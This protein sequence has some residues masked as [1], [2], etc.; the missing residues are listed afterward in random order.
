MDQSWDPPREAPPPQN[1]QRRDFPPQTPPGNADSDGWVVRP[2]VRPAAQEPASPGTTS[3]GRN[4][5][6]PLFDPDRDSDDLSATP[7]E[8]EKIRRILNDLD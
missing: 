3:A 6:P 1:G 7:E 5:T 2:V 8:I 4:F